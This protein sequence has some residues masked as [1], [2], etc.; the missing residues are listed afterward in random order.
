MNSSGATN[1]GYRAKLEHCLR[2]GIYFSSFAVCGNLC[3]QMQSPYETARAGY[4]YQFPRDHFNHPG[5]QTEW[6]YYTGNVVAGLYPAELAVRLN[7]LE[8][9][10]DE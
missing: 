8:V 1:R 6:W 5:Y 9:V 10:H 4:T 3:G 2:A 7:P